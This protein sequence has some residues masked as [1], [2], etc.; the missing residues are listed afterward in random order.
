MTEEGGE[1]L[2]AEASARAKAHNRL[3]EQQEV[4][5]HEIQE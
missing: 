4:Q 2:L 1:R 3:V 5:G